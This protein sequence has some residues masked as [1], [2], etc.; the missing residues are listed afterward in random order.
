MK[1]GEKL[2]CLQ[3]CWVLAGLS[4]TA[5]AGTAWTLVWSDEFS[6]PD[7]SSPDSTKWSYDIRAGGWGNN[8]L[9][10]YTSRTN[11]VRIEDGNLVIEARQENYFG[12]SYT[13]ARLKTQG[14][15]SWAY[16]RIEA[17]IKIP[18]G[19]GI[20]PAFW[21]LGTNCSSVGWPNCG[22]IDIMENIGREPAMVHA[23]VHGPGYSG[24]GAIGSPYSLPGIAAFADDFHNYALEWTT[25]RIKWFV[26][27]A[28]Y[29]SVNPASLPNG[30]TWVFTQPQFLLL[31]V[32]VGG[33]WPGNPDGTTTFPQR[34]QV[35]YVRAY[36]P[37]NLPACGANLL[38]NPG[39]DAGGLTNWTTYGAG[40]NTVLENIKNVPVHDGTNVF[41]LF[42]Q[43]NGG[44]NYSGIYQHVP[45]AAG[46][47]LT[48]NG[49]VLTPNGDSI[50][51]ANAAWIEVTFRDAATNVLGL[52]RST[53]INTN[54]AIGVWLDLAVTNQFDP[55]TF[56]V[57]GSVTNLVAPAGT[58]FARYQLVFRQ[59][60]NAAGAV[61]FDDLKLSPSG[62]SEIP[63]AAGLSMNGLNLSLSFPTFLGLAYQ[64]RFKN[65]LGDATWLV[66]TN[67]I[68]DGTTKLVS[69]VVVATRRFYQVACVCN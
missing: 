16:G 9:Q 6:Q 13:S 1:L 22:E 58:A 67:A 59:P 29:F 48:A 54:T 10:Y 47:S 24:G 31:N 39:F 40:F 55:S 25:N 56:T 32:A 57:I 49:W 34:M 20:W 26:D 37:S 42:G 35:D 66:M 52:Y 53:A 17:R 61:L 8:E 36:A 65:D 30:T 27:G 46:Q 62:S 33:Y 5:Q 44:E 64:V 2:R 11:N 63:V 50:A 3:V 21:A 69:D 51:G 41:K 23:T 4:A 28:Q 60:L 19:Q 7:G 38:N 15:A 12:S 43:F 68:G 45:A 18:R 14:K